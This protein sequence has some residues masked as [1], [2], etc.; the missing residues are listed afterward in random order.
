MSRKGGAGVRVLTFNGDGR[1]RAT[2]WASYKDVVRLPG[3][4][5]V[6]LRFNIWVFRLLTAV[7]YLLPTTDPDEDPISFE[8]YFEK[9]RT[10]YGGYGR[11]YPLPANLATNKWYHY[12]QV[13]DVTGGEGRAYL[14]GSL[15]VRESVSFLPDPHLR[16]VIM[17]QD[18]FKTPYSLSGKVSQVNAWSRILSDDEIARVARCE[19]NLEG[20]VIAWS[21][22]WLLYEVD[23]EE[24]PLQ[25]LCGS[26][27]GGMVMVPLPLL[28]FP[29]AVGL[30]RGLGGTIAVP[31]DRSQLIQELQ[32]FEGVEGCD[33]QWAGVTDVA[34]EGVWSNPF[35]GAA[36]N[37]S[38]IF[39]RAHN[40][41]GD[42]YQNCLRLHI[43]GLED[44][45]CEKH[46]C[47][48]CHTQSGTTWT[49]RGICEEEERMYYFDLIPN[50]LA[51]RGYGEY[52]VAAVE[53][54]GWVWH[55]TITNV[56]MAVLRSEHNDEFPVGRLTWEAKEEVCQDPPGDR[57]LTLSSCTKDEFT[58]TDGFCIPFQK[59][60]DLKFDCEDKT[61]ESFCDIIN[62]PT[63]YRSK[64][65]PRPGSD[66]ALPLSINV[67]MDTIN[68][69]TTTMLLSVSYNLRISWHDNRLTYN[70]LKKLTRLN[71]ISQDQV[72]LLW[73]P[74]I[75]FINTDDIQHT[76]V[77]AD[78][79]TT[80]VQDHDHYRLDFS[81]PYEVR[82]FRGDTNPISTTR[83][84]STVFTC[85]FDLVLYP[86]D[87]Q[88]CYI[89]LQIITASSEYLIY[90][91]TDSFVEYLG[92]R[93]LV[94][95]AIGVIDLHINNQSQ[96]S[97]SKV[98]VELVRR[99][100]YAMLNIYIP[101]LILLIISYVTLFFRPSI[102]EVR[103]MTALTS[104]L[105]LATLFT[106]VSASL[107]KTSYFKMVDIWLLF[108]IIIIFFIII[109][110]T[111]IDLHVDYG[112]K[113]TLSGG[114]WITS[115][116]ST[117]SRQVKVYPS[118]G[119][120]LNQN[121]EKT[122]KLFGRWTRFR[123]KLDLQFYIKT[124]KITMFVIFVLFN[125]TYWGTLAVDSGLVY[126]I[127]TD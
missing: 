121:A 24:I 42:K 36:H 17:G 64:L 3:D 110:H 19:D 70:N 18:E 9:I 91:A 68:I 26:M 8:V 89:H 23:E 79:V 124:S 16:N 82:I 115:P 100:G 107:P 11:F 63:D 108:C 81:N 33:R 85:F 58:C 125:T 45:S 27:V 32:H 61:D 120:N 43:K 48:A 35:T 37:T 53:G 98:R 96:Y 56:T 114:A 10:K 106:Q 62:F 75:G 25:K 127:S 52:E 2:T 41:D 112:D 14:D 22:E 30:C 51:F 1:Q 6:C 92:P 5:T 118:S 83:K 97:V 80:I 76:E 59:R 69:D 111:I 123:S 99:Y 102:F 34:Q 119:D 21:R 47:S 109:F 86:F 113:I 46:S 50:P 122:T 105:V 116:S 40:P 94:E 57:I 7:L 55:N 20:D 117:V 66:L 88:N 28:K 95:Y 4:Y 90:N 87:I 65:P 74:T 39:F 72:D 54:E 103:V 44:T 15:L 126:Y 93:L 77:D 84:Y 60:C 78:S 104:L 38:E 71:T 101:S 13:R 29:D 31:G 73:R 12:C 67:S 49:L